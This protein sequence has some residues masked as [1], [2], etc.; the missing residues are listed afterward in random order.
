MNIDRHDAFHLINII[1]GKTKESTIMKQSQL[2]QEVAV[3]TLEL[4]TLGYRLSHYL[5]KPLILSFSQ[6]MTTNDGRFVFYHDWNVI[7]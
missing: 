1:K 3:T 7:I 2:E 5:V 6:L 4:S